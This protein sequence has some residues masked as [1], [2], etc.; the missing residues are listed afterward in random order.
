MLL[1]QRTETSKEQLPHGHL[2]I[3]RGNRHVAAS[4][5][6]ITRGGLAAFSIRVFRKACAWCL[7]V[8]CGGSRLRSPNPDC[9][10]KRRERTFYLRS[11]TF[12]LDPLSVLDDCRQARGTGNDSGTSVVG[13]LRIQTGRLVETARRLNRTAST[14]EWTFHKILTSR[15]SQRGPAIAGTMR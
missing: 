13:S 4:R 10:G 12:P 6:W 15:R 1:R 14:I 7:L 9:S 11:V 2:S 5:R 3:V 8:F